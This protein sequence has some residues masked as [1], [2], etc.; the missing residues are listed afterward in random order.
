MTFG[1]NEQGRVVRKKRT[2]TCR[3]EERTGTCRTEERTGMCRTGTCRTLM[4]LTEKAR[5]PA[6]T[7]A[8][9]SSFTGLARNVSTQSKITVLVPVPAIPI[10]TSMVR[11]RKVH[12]QG[13]NCCHQCCLSGSFYHQAKIGPVKGMDPD[14]SIKQKKKTL[15][16][17]VPV[18]TGKAL[19][20][21]M[22]R[23]AAR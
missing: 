10:T 5:S 21:K 19:R 1:R 14:P 6:Y 4:R 15:T 12:S 16:T 23:K 2:G 17:T 7:T 9:A 18:P 22:Q 8:C 20:Y 13:M 11:E 3:T